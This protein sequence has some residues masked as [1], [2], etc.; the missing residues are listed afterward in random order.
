MKGCHLQ[1][2]IEIMFVFTVIHKTMPEIV[3]NV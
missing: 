1:H 3:F 2:S